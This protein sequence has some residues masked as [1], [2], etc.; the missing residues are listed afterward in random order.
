MGTYEADSLNDTLFPSVYTV[1]SAVYSRTGDS[2][3]ISLSGEETLVLPAE[4]Y[5]LS[6]LREGSELS[7]DE[8]LKFKRVEAA[9][10]ARKKAVR[11]LDQRAYTAAQLKRKLAEA[12]YPAAVIK[13]VIDDLAARGFL[14]DR[15]YAEGWIASQIRRKPQGR[16]LLY[17][18]LVRKGVARREAEQLIAA[19]YPAAQE[20]EQ[21]RICM[22]K[23]A[24]RRGWEAESLL[25][26]VA[27]RGFEMSLIKKVYREL[28]ARR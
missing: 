5:A 25:P 27:R 12:M 7:R 10:L 16:R 18:G 11:L 20:E 13:E 19:G 14:D 1:L 24:A 22:K 2:V 8:L 3:K 15:K 4:G 26:A 6:Q 23:F 9:F 28:Q 21:C 17:M